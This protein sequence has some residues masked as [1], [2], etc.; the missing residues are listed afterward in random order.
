MR[1]R[2]VYDDAEQHPRQGNVCGVLRRAVKFVRHLVASEAADR[3][4]AKGCGSI[5]HGINLG[6]GFENGS[7]VVH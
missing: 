7:A 4:V 5:G 3:S 2:A 1:V 6:S